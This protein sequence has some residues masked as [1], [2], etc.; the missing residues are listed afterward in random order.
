MTLYNVGKKRCKRK[1]WFDA[2]RKICGKT[3][4]IKRPTK[5]G[6]SLLIL[7][8]WF[9]LHEGMRIC[10]K[11]RRGSAKPEGGWGDGGM[12]ERILW[13]DGGWGKV[14]LKIKR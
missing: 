1:P 8:G 4:G 7:F 6:K 12:G 11:E 14:P 10:R 5:V 3:K 13:G 9:L 2:K